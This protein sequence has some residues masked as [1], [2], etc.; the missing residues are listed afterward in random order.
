M[1][2]VELNGG[3]RGYVGLSDEPKPSEPDMVTGSMLIE[4]DTGAV[5]YYDADADSWLP[6]G[7]GA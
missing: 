5:K 6:F 1:Q 4:L 3:F 7:G 2:M